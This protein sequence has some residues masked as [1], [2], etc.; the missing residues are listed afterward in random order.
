MTHENVLNAEHA[1]KH[2]LEAVE[3]YKISRLD[4]YFSDHRCLFGSK[5]TGT[6]KHSSMLLTRA[7][8]KMRKAGGK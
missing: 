5:Y 4:P 1:A 8:A 7:L 3:E 2:F 6:L